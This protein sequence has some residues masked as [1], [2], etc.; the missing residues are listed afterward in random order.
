MIDDAMLRNLQPGVGSDERSLLGAF[1]E[2]R[3]KVLEIANRQYVGG[4]QNRYS[5]S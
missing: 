1:D 4:P 5:I 3:E 2:F